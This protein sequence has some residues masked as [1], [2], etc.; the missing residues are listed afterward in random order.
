M[1]LG[2]HV[3]DL[4]AE[5]APERR[6]ALDRGRVGILRRREDAPAV[7]EQLGEA[8]IRTGMLGA[9]HRMRGHEMDAGRQVRG[10]VAHDRRLDRPDVGDGRALCEVRSDLLRHRAAG[11]DRNADDDEIGARNRRLVGLDHLIGEAELGDAPA[12][13]GRARGRHDRAHGALG[14][15][16]ARDRGADQADTDERQ[17]VVERGDRH[18]AF[19]KN[20]ASAATTSVFASSLPTV[21]RSAFG[22]L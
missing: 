22:S 11:A 19:P 14:A 17:T 1:V 12:R 7:D 13:L 2:R 10:H 15:R 8:R 6:Q 21:M 9:G 20:S 4:G 5:A 3:A 16:G 18:R